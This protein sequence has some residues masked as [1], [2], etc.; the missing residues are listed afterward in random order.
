M[1]KNPIK[2]SKGG[3]F[4]DGNADP[5]PHELAMAKALAKAGYIIRFLPNPTVI[6]TADAHIENTI[7]EF[8]APEGSSVKSIERNIVKALN[9]Q[10]TNIVIATFRMKNIQDR[11]A[12]NY[13][14]TLL[15]AGKGIQRLMLITRDNKVIDINALLR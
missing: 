14:I 12:Q 2:H 6:G 1:K 10:S 4:V 11:S 8:K 13:L 3:Y 7:F 5:K 9:H 15:K